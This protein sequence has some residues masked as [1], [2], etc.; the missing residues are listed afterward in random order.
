MKAGSS[1]R[2]GNAPR[3][4]NAARAIP[5]SESQDV[6]TKNI[7]CMLN[8]LRNYYFPRNEEGIIC[9]YKNNL[10]V[11]FSWVS[12]ARII[13]I[14][15]DRAGK[16]FK[17]LAHPSSQSRPNPTYILLVKCPHMFLR[18]SSGGYT[19]DSPQKIYS[20]LFLNSSSS[21][22]KGFCLTLAVKP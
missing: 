19:H 9:L 4:S 10:K 2:W 12:L 21:F 5:C 6:S 7:F 16:K 1:G 11:C 18:A 3:G 14:L 15:R 8:Y 17:E 22:L 13:V 20:I